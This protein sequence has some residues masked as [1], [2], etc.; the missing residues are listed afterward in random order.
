MDL[1]EQIY[2]AGVVGAGGAG[3]PSH[4]KLNCDVEYFIVNAAECEPLLQVDKLLMRKWADKIVKGIEEIGKMVKAKYIVIAIKEKYKDEIK[5]LRYAIE[6]VNSNI[7]LFYLKNYYPAG[8]EQMIV[9]EVTGRSIPEGGIPLDVKAVV[10]NIGTILNIYDAINGIPVI[11]K[12]ISVI[13][14]VNKPTFLK[15]PIGVSLEDCIEAS[16][17]SLLEEYSIIIGGPMM[18]KVIDD[19]DVS[20]TF[21]EKTTS[22]LIIIPKD[23]Y[24]LQR[25]KKSLKTI[26]NETKSACIQCRYCT[27]L[28]PRFLIGHKLRPHKIMRNIGLENRDKEIIKE[29]LICCE[30]GVCEMYSCPMGLSPR[31]VNS[32]LKSQ[33]R[34]IGVRVSKGKENIS[35]NEMIE[36]RKIPTARLM[37]RLDITKYYQQHISDIEEI[38]PKKVT[39]SLSQHIGKQAKPIVE[40][41]EMVK[42]GQLIG[43]VEKENVGANLHATI[44]GVVNLLGD[45]ILIQEI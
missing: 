9:Y 4:I 16:G 34:E 17:G 1:L 23:H 30:C 37:A 40:N 6:K 26:I 11:N 24:I 43:V 44:D 3:F 41:G 42:K 31:L 2:K 29:A 14:E 13:G 22:S 32:Y 33:L 5:S 36:Y 35:S 19:I 28:C 8:D 15:V 10:S 20:K 12:Y 39:I 45:K 21:I 7:K 38:S 25:K 27:D 18:G